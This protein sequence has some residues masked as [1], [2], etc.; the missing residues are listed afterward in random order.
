M[1]RAAPLKGP[2][3]ILGA[4]GMLGRAVGG[5]CAARGIEALRR[6]KADCDIT[7]AASVAAALPD[8]AAAVINCAAFTDVDG[9]ETR[10]EAAR[11]VNAHGPR[12]VAE[13]CRA[14]GAVLV[15]FSTDYVFDGRSA[16]PYRVG[17]ALEPVN[18]YGRS[19]AEGERLVHESGARHLILRTSWLYAPWG[20]NFVRTIARLGSERP[21]L[22]VVDDQRGRPSSCDLLAETTLAMLGAGAEGVHHATDGGECT[23]FEFATAIVEGLGLPARV[24]PCTSA[25]FPRPATRPAYS[26]LDLSETERLVGPRRVWRECLRDTLQR[27]ERP[28]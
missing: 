17:R 5:A 12:V 15:H 7:D 28:L 10:F 26:V 22:K 23:W 2:F 16:A 20:K 24:E 14:V 19:K 9:A 27:L 18:A 13:R 6:T 1:G 21:V 4:G 8:G 11:S 25:E 3:V